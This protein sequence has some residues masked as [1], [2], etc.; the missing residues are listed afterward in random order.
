MVGASQAAVERATR[1]AEPSADINGI[2]IIEISVYGWLIPCLRAISKTRISNH[3]SHSLQ[4]GVSCGQHTLGE[5]L[6][7]GLSS[8]GSHET[9]W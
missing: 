5:I 7:V 4:E 2:E 9:N 8:S 6:L 3:A 1:I